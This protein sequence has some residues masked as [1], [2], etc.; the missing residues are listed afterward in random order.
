MEEGGAPNNNLPQGRD[1]EDNDRE[2]YVNFNGRRAKGVLYRINT[3]PENLRARMTTY[4]NEG[5]MKRD[6]RFAREVFGLVNTSGRKEFDMFWESPWIEEHV[7]DA[8][9]KRKLEAQQR[10]MAVRSYIRASSSVAQ[11]PDNVGKF[12]DTV[13]K[14]TDWEDKHD[15]KENVKT[16]SRILQSFERVAIRYLVSRCHDNAFDHCRENVLRHLN[17]RG[18]D[19]EYENADTATNPSVLANT[20]RRNDTLFDTFAAVVA[21][22]I[23]WADA[24]NGTRNTTNI[25]CTHLKEKMDLA[26]T[27]MI[28]V[29]NSFE[30]A[31]PLDNLGLPLTEIDG[32]MCVSKGVLVVCPGQETATYILD[33]EPRPGDEHRGMMMDLSNVKT[34]SISQYLEEREDGTL[35]SV[36]SSSRRR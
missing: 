1:E 17:I 31:I 2:G 30:D 27:I 6:L 25:I 3:M 8:P 21:S 24:T 33:I 16:V 12:L 9:K 28:R 35:A 11:D 7:R 32:N 36:P 5:F 22:Q 23:T 15:A 13:D 34:I 19:L 20:F 26:A 10:S 4:V 29:L 14:L 18:Q